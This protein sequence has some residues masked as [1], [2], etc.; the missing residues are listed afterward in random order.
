MK[1]RQGRQDE[2]KEDRARKARQVRGNT[3]GKVSCRQ[4]EQGAGRED[5]ARQSMRRQI[6]ARRGRE[7]KIRCDQIR[8]GEARQGKTKQVV[9]G[10]AERPGNPVN[11]I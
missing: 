1:H 11:H 3:N 7:D 9:L 10:E 5:K 4:A 6:M 8:R 2:V